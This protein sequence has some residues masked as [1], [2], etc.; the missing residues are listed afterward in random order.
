MYTVGH[1][2]SVW[3]PLKLLIIY[4]SSPV[5]REGKEDSEQWWQHRCR[6]AAKTFTCNFCEIYLYTVTIIRRWGHW[7]FQLTNTSSRTMTLSS[8]QPLN[9]NEYQE[10]SWG[11]RCVQRVRLTASLSSELFVC[12]MWEPRRLT[13]PVTG[14]ALH[15][16]YLY[17]MS[18][19]NISDV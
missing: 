10:P 11:W 18:L 1:P 13:C 2:H 5:Y 12:K 6:A 9:R 7:I 14:I 4:P 19:F 17:Y 8:T 15:F 3:L 16:F